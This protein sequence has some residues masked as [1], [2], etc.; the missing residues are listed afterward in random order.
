MIEETFRW[1]LVISVIG[2]IALPISMTLFQSLPGR[3][4][5]FAK[6][7]GLLLTGYLF[8]LA[9]SLHVMPNRPGTIVWVLIALVAVDY[10]ILR[11]RW[12]TYLEALED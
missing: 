7:L 10:F 9:L 3:G 2:L 5:A 12:R 1:W 6:P 4:M 8:W 11:R